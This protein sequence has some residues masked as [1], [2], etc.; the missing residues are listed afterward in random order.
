VGRGDQSSSLR[1]AR[2]SL[3]VKV[4]KVLLNESFIGLGTGNE[5]LDSPNP[6]VSSHP[7][8]LSSNRRDE[9]NLRQTFTFLS[10]TI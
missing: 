3:S 10:A 7:A 2:E 9:V 6:L 4:R 5:F 8:V 1:Y